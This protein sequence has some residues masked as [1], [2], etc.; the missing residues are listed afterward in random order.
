MKTYCV[1]GV[2]AGAQADAAARG[3]VRLEREV[4]EELPAGSTRTYHKAVRG[5]VGK[6]ICGRE[7]ADE[8]AANLRSQGYIVT[9]RRWK[10]RRAAF[11]S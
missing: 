8:Y 5:Q 9:L 2:P 11:A 1:T 7:A 6:I 4:R 3:R 10:P